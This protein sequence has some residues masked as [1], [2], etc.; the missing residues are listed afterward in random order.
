MASIRFPNENSHC[1][2]NSWTQYLHTWYG[3]PFPHRS[4]F[5]FGMQESLL[6][7]SKPNVSFHFRIRFVVNE[8]Q[9][10]KTQTSKTWQQKFSL[11]VAGNETMN[12][13]GRTISSASVS[14]PDW[15]MST[16][17]VTICLNLHW[18]DSP[19]EFKW[20]YFMQIVGF[21]LLPSMLD[22]FG[23]QTTLPF[24]ISKRFKKLPCSTSLA[25]LFLNN[26]MPE[27]HPRSTRDFS[28][29]INLEKRI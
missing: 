16:F 7:E 9:T 17:C 22:H 23:T 18:C 4:N 27:K 5:L 1:C 29:R 25:H 24:A 15:S 28:N 20:M 3:Q 12:L 13:D 14:T 6:D 21:V 19:S 26:R 11:Q 2:Q 8:L 10:L